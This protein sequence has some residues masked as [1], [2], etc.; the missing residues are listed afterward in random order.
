LEG[1]E[2]RTVLSFFAPVSYPAN[3]APAAVAVGDFNGDG[4]PD[5]IT[6]NT[7]PGTVNVLLDNGDGT[8]QAP[9]TSSTSNNPVE[10]RADDIDG[11]GKE[12]IVTIGSYDTSGGGKGAA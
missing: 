12:D 7:S 8:F 9:I 5:V 11:D 4:K 3:A 2:Q 1:L 6:A 10:V